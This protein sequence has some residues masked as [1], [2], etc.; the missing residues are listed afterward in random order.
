[1]NRCRGNTIAILVPRQQFI[2]QTYHVSI[3]LSFS[4]K[5]TF[6]QR[7][8]TDFRH[9]VVDQAWSSDK[10]GHASNSND[11][12]FF[13]IQ[14]PRQE[15]A[16]EHEMGCQIDLHDRINKRRGGIED[17]LSST[18]QRSIRNRMRMSS[19]VLVPTDASVVDQH[20]WISKSTL[21]LCGRR[22]NALE[23]SHIAFE[24]MNFW[25]C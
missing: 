18:Y 11:M 4:I 9:T 16:N 3:V 1:M 7:Q 15:L 21:D 24:V 5:L 25:Y 13:R 19:H 2:S 17:R 14:H 22:R 20:G 8:N 12:T 6:N 10:T 23:I